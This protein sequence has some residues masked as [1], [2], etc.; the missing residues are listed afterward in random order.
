MAS[1][2]D[3]GEPAATDS[4]SDDP[5]GRLLPRPGRSEQTWAGAETQEDDPDASAATSGSPE[6][7][8][9]ERYQEMADGVIGRGGMGRVEVVFD[10][11]LGRPVAR[12]VLDPASGLVTT[13]MT[14]RFLREVRVTA[15]LEHPGIVPVHDLVRMED[16]RPAYTMKRVQGQTLADA[17]SQAVDLDARLSL[18]GHLE[19]VC[20]ALAF[21]HSEGVVHRDLKPDN[22]LIG[23]FGETVVIDWG[24]ARVDG[25]VDE[26]VCADSGEVAPGL[27]RAG[28]V[29]G[30]PRYMSPEQARALHDEVDART[31]V[32]ALGLML[33]VV[34]T[35]RAPHG[36][37]DA[38]TLLERARRGVCPDR[39]R[40]A[41]CRPLC[42]IADKAT[43][44][45]AEERYA[46]AAEMAADVAAWRSGRPVRAHRYGVVDQIARVVQH[47]RRAASVAAVAV[48]L[49][50]L[51]SGAYAV[52][53]AAAME[54]ASQE[55]LLAEQAEHAAQVS[56]LRAAAG[57]AAALG[58]G[59]RELALLW[60]ANEA[61]G[62]RTGSL[63]A[64]LVRAVE[65]AW[66]QSLLHAGDVA[67]ASLLVPGSGPVAAVLRDGRLLLGDSDGLTVAPW[68]A[69]LDETVLAMSAE[70]L[71]G[72]EAGPAALT[73]WARDAKGSLR[74]RWSVPRPMDAH[75]ERFEAYLIQPTEDGGVVVGT[76]A[77][78]VA[79]LAPGGAGVLVGRDE[80]LAQ[81]DALAF[82][83]R[84]G[85]VYAAAGLDSRIRRWAWPSGMAL[86]PIDVG[87]SVVGL[88]PVD[89]AD[90]LVS[91]EQSG[92][93]R[94]HT[95]EGSLVWTRELGT[96]GKLVRS[97][98]GTRLAVQ[99]R[100]GGVH[101]IDLRTGDELWRRSVGTALRSPALAF[102]ADGDRLVVALP[103]N[104]AMVLG[105]ADGSVVARM[106]G[107]IR[108][109]SGLGFDGTGAVWLASEDGS[110]RR[111]EE[112]G[113]GEAWDWSSGGGPPTALARSQDGDAVLVGDATGAVHRVDPA[114]QA[115]VLFEGTGRSVCAVG[116]EDQAWVALLADV[117][118]DRDA[119]PRTDMDRN[120][121]QLVRGEPGT[122]PRLGPVQ[123]AQGPVGLLWRPRARSSSM[124]GASRV[125]AGRN[126]RWSG[127]WA[128]LCD[129]VLGISRALPMAGWW[130]RRGE[131]SSGWT[132]QASHASS[133]RC[134]WPVRR[135]VAR[136]GPS[137]RPPGSESWMQ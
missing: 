12:K 130:L 70:G 132:L 102:S 110:V 28:N 117:C 39:F 48:G 1:P 127:A 9:P 31:D 103:S 38:E 46:N 33:R 74:M 75:P 79:L 7:V 50:L 84:R 112:S 93:L 41:R 120:G 95:L 71:V 55:K 47:N 4:R 26:V 25:E 108:L 87:A 115:N 100:G 49:G 109:L 62:G 105:V 36:E 63:R 96:R 68:R 77:G 18:L 73:A 91:L 76:D 101:V 98:D 43:A 59:D 53:L 106:G 94:A 27:T 88:L 8:P 24:L 136:C 44:R 133:L 67:V 129:G 57:R 19:D 58:H 111:F 16:G 85:I 121:W 11:L 45:H 32:W 72:A 37:G 30:T 34:L 40:G 125:P 135:P 113:A 42:A 122:A 60:A 97:P 134:V 99:T 21:A 65:A 116:V 123:W 5:F 64:E 128:N 118:G 3:E 89:D 80:Q 14:T 52:R 78:G 114:G 81:V 104:G 69:P 131:P 66:P 2:P 22:V 137:P 13:S 6:P 10:E 54:V 61:D 124:M 119:L 86:P 83:Y 126:S 56:M 35:G 17:L 90:R 51:L 92:V 15:R 82:S 23:A 20:N 107:S 29:L